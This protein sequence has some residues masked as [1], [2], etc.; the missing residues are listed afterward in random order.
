MP[1]GPVGAVGREALLGGDARLGAEAGLGGVARL[2]GD[3]VEARAWLS[4]STAGAT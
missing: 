1:D 4:P 3:A 2:A